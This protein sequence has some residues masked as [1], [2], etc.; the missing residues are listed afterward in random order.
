MKG[1]E[2]DLPIETRSVGEFSL[3]PDIPEVPSFQLFYSNPIS[4][5]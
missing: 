1:E 4:L 2:S 5:Y 3:Q